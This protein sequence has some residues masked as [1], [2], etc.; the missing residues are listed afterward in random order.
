MLPDQNIVSIWIVLH[1]V[2][3]FQLYAGWKH[4]MLREHV[5]YNSP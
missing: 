3:V 1:N 5:L 4:C 2:Q